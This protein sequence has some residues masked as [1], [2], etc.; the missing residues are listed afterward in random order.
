MARFFIAASNIFG[1]V[2]YLNAEEAEHIRV[3][4]IRSGETFTVCDGNGNDYVCRLGEKTSD[5]ISAEILETL[6]STG[7][8]GVECT[9]YAALPKGDKAETII[10]KSVELGAAS[11]VFFPSARCVSRPS[12]ASLISKLGRW[13]KIAAEAAKQSGRGRIPTVSALSSFVLAM[14]EAAKTDLPLFLYEDEQ[15]L[16]LRAAIEG[17]P[18]AKTVS[19]VTGPEGGFEKEEVEAAKQAGLLSVSLG[20]RI[21]RCETAPLAA[22]TAVM[23]MSG[24]LE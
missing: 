19:V 9:V 14:D 5:G 17:K 16:S 10:Q 13:Q 22:L 3:L 15:G 8:P 1:G 11:I 4:R 24:N 23:L 21:L 6:P 12:E 18:D 7:E 2:A 20:K